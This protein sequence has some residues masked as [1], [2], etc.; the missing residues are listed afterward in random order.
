MECSRSESESAR[1]HLRARVQTTWFK[2]VEMTC[3]T[4]QE[5]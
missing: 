5:L 3:V 4:R 2:T 1:V